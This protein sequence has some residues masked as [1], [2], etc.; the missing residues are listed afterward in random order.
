MKISFSSDWIEVQMNG[1]YLGSSFL[2][3]QTTGS[4]RFSSNL[5]SSFELK[6][7][8]DF[9]LQAVYFGDGF[10]GGNWPHVNFWFYPDL[11]QGGRAQFLNA[12]VSAANTRKT[13]EVCDCIRDTGRKFETAVL[14]CGVD[15]LIDGIAIQETIDN[16][17]GILEKAKRFSKEVIVCTLTPRTDG[18]MGAEKD[19]NEYLRG[20]NSR[21]GVTVA[22]VALAFQ[23][24]PRKGSLTTSGFPNEE[25]QSLIAEVVRKAWS[26]FTE[27]EGFPLMKKQTLASRMVFRFSQKVQRLAAILDR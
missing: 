25:G 27:G 20:L 4:V 9:D 2:E 21:E 15:D 14:M 7:G 3:S 1:Q 13:L 11:L 23:E 18:L 22:D 24:H 5:E 8:S 19:I 17:E 6:E 12:G 26:K 16:F 10:T